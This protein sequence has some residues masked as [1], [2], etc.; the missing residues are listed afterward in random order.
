M[1]RSLLAQR[2]KAFRERCKDLG[3]SLTYQRLSIYK[4]LLQVPDHPS[5]DAIYQVVRKTYPSISLATV[6]KTLDRFEKS[7]LVSKVNPLHETA[8]Y[9]PKVEHHHHLVC[10]E[11]KHV[12]DLDPQ[13]LTR[14]LPLDPRSLGLPEGRC[15]DFDVVDYTI[16]F[17]GVCQACRRRLA[18]APRTGA[19]GA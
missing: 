6:Y 12:E 4:A 18:R 9:D 17:K 11:C 2:M 8:R 7:G 16:T 19:G 13:E 14:P 5:P 10:T 15:R 1:K 3:L